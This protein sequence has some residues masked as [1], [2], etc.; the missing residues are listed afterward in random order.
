MVT[1]K[2]IFKIV[3]DVDDDKEV[4][5]IIAESFKAV[6]DIAVVKVKCRRFKR[7]YTHKHKKLV[8]K[9]DVA[10]MEGDD[11][12]SLEVK[13]VMDW[14]EEPEEEPEELDEPSV[15]DVSSM[16]DSRVFF[17]NLTTPKSMD[18]RTNIL[19]DALA[20][21]VNIENGKACEHDEPITIQEILGYLLARVNRRHKTTMNKCPQTDLKNVGLSIFKGESSTKKQKLV[22]VCDAVALKHWIELSKDDM[23]KMRSYLNK[24]DV[25]FPTTNARREETS[26]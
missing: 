6:V 23:R 16:P 4:V 14:M 9:Q 19:M 5:S 7:L 13:K 3:A 22:P 25:E 1:E 12:I 26:S 15:L 10:E 8:K 2:D 20:Q 18:V 21:W 24:F 17:K 11:Q